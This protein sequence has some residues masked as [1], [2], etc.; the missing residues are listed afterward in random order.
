MSS[1]RSCRGLLGGALLGSRVGRLHLI[2]SGASVLQLSVL[3]GIMGGEGSGVDREACLFYNI[4]FTRRRCIA[5]I[6]TQVSE[7][8]AKRTAFRTAHVRGG[9]ILELESGPLRGNIDDIW[10]V[11]PCD[12]PRTV[13]DGQPLTYDLGQD[14]RE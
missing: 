14:G 9:R 6:S 8:R 1:G 7:V 4:H 5:L 10:N 13:T 2:T 12:Q 3:G 11:Q